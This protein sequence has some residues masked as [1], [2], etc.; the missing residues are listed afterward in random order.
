MHLHK[1]KGQELQVST[2]RRAYAVVAHSQKLGECCRACWAFR[3]CRRFLIQADPAL[4]QRNEWD[5]CS[6]KAK[7]RSSAHHVGCRLV[8]GTFL[9]RCSSEDQWDVPCAL[10]R[11]SQRRLAC[12]STGRQ[13]HKDMPQARAR[14]PASRASEAFHSVP[15]WRFRWACS[16]HCSETRPD[17]VPQAHRWKRGMCR[18]PMPHAAEL[19]HQL[20]RELYRVTG[21]AVACHRRFVKVKEAPRDSKLGPQP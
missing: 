9:L 20:R 5:N 21:Q 12:R 10:L 13:G 11:G 1:N 2:V 18:A 17:E 7:N 3:C 8:V 19:H 6:A 14:W 16:P 15:D 4:L